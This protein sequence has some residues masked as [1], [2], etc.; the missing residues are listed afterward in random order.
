MTVVASVTTASGEHP[1]QDVPGITRPMT[2]EEYVSGLEEMARYDI[3]DGWKVYRRYGE[4]RS[5]SLAPSPIFKS[6]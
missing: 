4:N 3:I 5:L 6:P 1:E 2:Y